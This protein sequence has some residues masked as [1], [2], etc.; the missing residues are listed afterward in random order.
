ME[1]FEKRIRPVGF[2]RYVSSTFIGKKQRRYGFRSSD[3]FRAKRKKKHC[4]QRCPPPP[5]HLPALTRWLSI[6]LFNFVIEMPTFQCL[7]KPE[8]LT[9]ETV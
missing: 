9:G 3:F 8:M 6:V 7:C 1:V 2:Y 5:M 4:T